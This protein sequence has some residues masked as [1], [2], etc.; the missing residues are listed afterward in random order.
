MRKLSFKIACALLLCAL[1]VSYFFSFYKLV[2]AV[3][4]ETITENLIIK[5]NEVNTQF[6]N[7]TVIMNAN[8]IIEE[9]ATL[10]LNHTT[11]L[12]N[13]TGAAQYNITLRNPVN[14]Q[15][16]LWAISSNVTRQGLKPISIYSTGGS[17]TLTQTAAPSSIFTVSN[18][19]FLTVSGQKSEIPQITARESSQVSLTDLKIAVA[20]LNLINSTAVLSNSRV[21]KLSAN[22]NANVTILKGEVVDLSISTSVGDIKNG[23]QITNLKIT[24]ST[25]SLANSTSSGEILC[26]G[27]TNLT[28]NKCQPPNYVLSSLKA[29][30]DTRISISNSQMITFALY[31][32]SQATLK[33]VRIVGFISSIY[34]EGRTKANVSESEIA[35]FTVNENAKVSIENSTID[36]I[37]ALK[38]S[39]TTIS[40]VFV[41]EWLRT[42][43]NAV[44]RITKSTMYQVLATLGSS[45]TSIA[46]SSLNMVSTFDS[47]IL[48]VNSSSITLLYNLDSSNTTVSNSQI[49]ELQIEARSVTGRINGFNQASITYWNLM[50]NNSIQLRPS[51]SYIPSL[52]LRNMQIPQNISF[53]FFGSSNITIANA[54]FKTIG[55]SDNTIIRVENSSIGSYKIKGSSKIYSYWYLSIRVLSPQK[56]PITGATVEIID[57]DGDIMDSGVTDLD[58]WFRS[59]KFLEASVVTATGP[60][61]SLILEV[62]KEDYFIRRLAAE[63]TSK[64]IALELPIPLPWWQQ[65]WYALVADIVL[66]VLIASIIAFRRRKAKP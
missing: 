36:Q 17:L 22:N 55:A 21:S 46:D 40:K 10:F 5:G 29:Y 24:N 65:Y 41:K 56:A 33:N 11:L 27:T 32:N 54:N 39:N 60:E 16:R 3:E 20:A 15:P 8:I 49:K 53:F 50:Q 9:N 58:G 45:I 14:G 37:L 59:N 2:Y 38:D 34:I 1:M 35:Y 12:F 66:V 57:S 61:K 64:I 13:Q 44:T 62:V 51:D 47:S 4:F 6:V 52:T 31:N 19:S 18:S 25:V 43:D 30:N 26:M 7:K 63:F 28:V 48:S 23:S 42:Y